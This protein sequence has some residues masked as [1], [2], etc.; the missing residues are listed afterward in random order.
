MKKLVLF[1]VFTG[2]ALVYPLIYLYNKCSVEDTAPKG[3]LDTL[4]LL[5]VVFVSQSVIVLLI[6]GLLGVLT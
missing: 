5:G 3:T 6:A 1:L 2:R 4:L